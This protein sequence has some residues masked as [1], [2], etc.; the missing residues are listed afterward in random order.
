MTSDLHPAAALHSLI[1]RIGRVIAADDRNG[2]L[3]PAQAAALGYLA[4]ANRF[5]RKPS[6]V[7]EYLGA[8]RGTVSQTLK[9]LVRKGMVTEAAAPDDKRSISYEVTPDGLAALERESSL[10][11]AIADMD[12]EEAQALKR[13]LEALMRRLLKARSMRSFG[14]CKTCRFHERR[15]GARHC[16]LLDV[17]LAEGEATRIC[18]EHQE[19]PVHRSPSR[20][21]S[22][23]V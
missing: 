17:H 14:L 18:V 23:V 22:D 3:N 21:S 1:E 7:A 2:V 11:T 16:G 12:P 10:A 4:R 20:D 15:D 8:T 9:V 6:I 19:G 5:S 13:A